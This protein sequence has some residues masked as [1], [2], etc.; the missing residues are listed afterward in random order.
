MPGVPPLK[1]NEVSPA[2]SSI[3][4]TCFRDLRINGGWYPLNEAEMSL[5]GVNGLV[6]AIGKSSNSLDKCSDLTACPSGVKCP[7]TLTCQPTW[8]PPNGYMCT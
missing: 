2:D 6:T 4:S 8:K 1:P 3:G 5:A 7:G